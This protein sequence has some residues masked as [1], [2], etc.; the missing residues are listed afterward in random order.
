[1]GES[2]IRR[3]ACVARRPVPRAQIVDQVLREVEVACLVETAHFDVQRIQ[4]RMVHRICRPVRLGVH[5]RRHVHEV[6]EFTRHMVSLSHCVRRTRHRS[7]RRHRVLVIKEH[8]VPGRSGPLVGPGLPLASFLLAKAWLELVQGLGAVDAHELSLSLR[9]TVAVH[10]EV[11]RSLAHRRSQEGSVIE[12]ASLLPASVCF[13]VGAGTRRLWLMVK[14]DVAID[15][16]LVNGSGLEK[17]SAGSATGLRPRLI[18]GRMLVDNLAELDLI[19]RI[20]RAHRIVA[21]N[22]VVLITDVL[23]V[24]VRHQQA[25]LILLT[26]VVALHSILIFLGVRRCHVWLLAHLLVKRA[27]CFHLSVHLAYRCCYSNVNF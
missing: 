2:A 18:V 11:R 3:A 7:L 23:A 4:I 24:L 14:C 26:K 25:G 20:R 15:K 8:P 6:L 12:Q 22:A 21:R 17:P 9:Q 16:L 19:G 13:S 27:L 10:E 5:R 1:M